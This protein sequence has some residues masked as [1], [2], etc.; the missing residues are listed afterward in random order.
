MQ[1]QLHKPF[2]AN[3]DPSC[4]LHK[5]TDHLLYWIG[6]AK[7]EVPE[8]GKVWKYGVVVF[9]QARVRTKGGGGAPA[10]HMHHAY[11][12]PSDPFPGAIQQ[13]KHLVVFGMGSVTTSA[14]VKSLCTIRQITRG[15]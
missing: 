4:S 3:I 10:S 9:G 13:E 15:Q 8:K 6:T 11:G 5:A 14:L 7:T 1:V 2:D 12:T